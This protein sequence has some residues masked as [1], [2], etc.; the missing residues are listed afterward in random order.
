M[1]VGAGVC[2]LFIG[3]IAAAYII[4]KRRRRRRARGDGALEKDGADNPGGRAAV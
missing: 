1:G 4:G 2:I 3:S